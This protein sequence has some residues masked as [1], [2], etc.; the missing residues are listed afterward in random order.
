MIVP[1][2]HLSVMK[3][4]E[5]SDAEAEAVARVLRQAID[6]IGLRYRSI[7]HEYPRQCQLM[8]P[9]NARKPS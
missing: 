2:A 7:S 4:L 3:N 8:L 1:R 9:L 5:L 6:G